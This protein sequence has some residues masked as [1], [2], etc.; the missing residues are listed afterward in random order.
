V[1]AKERTLLVSNSNGDPS[2]TGDKLNGL[3]MFCIPAKSPSAIRNA[4]K[5]LV[6]LAEMVPEVLQLP[7]VSNGGVGKM[8]V[9]FQPV[10]T[11]GGFKKNAKALT[12]TFLNGVMSLPME[13]WPFQRSSRC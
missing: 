4:V 6:E 10:T 12:E 1:F 2:T 3:T 5:G 11:F 13:R 9:L 7:S 8:L